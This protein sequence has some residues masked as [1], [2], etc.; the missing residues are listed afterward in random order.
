VN[1]IFGV[2]SLPQS[3]SQLHSLSGDYN[4]TDAADAMDWTP[5]VGYTRDEAAELL[6][7]ARFAP[8]KPTGLEGLIEK[9]GLSEDET[10][11]SASNERL[12]TEARVSGVEKGIF[13][14]ALSAL[15]LVGI[16]AF[17]VTWW[18]QW[19]ASQPS[20]IQVLTPQHIVDDL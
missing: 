5:S 1:P 2:T 15:S 3:Q 16:I 8:E 6:R 18:P 11:G 14:G 4:N 20:G 10:R 12:S 17:V 13:I 7:P 9:F 19:V